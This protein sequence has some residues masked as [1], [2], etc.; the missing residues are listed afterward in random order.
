MKIMKRQL[1]L[2][3]I[4]LTMALGMTGCKGNN[5]GSKSKSSGALPKISVSSE[6][7]VTEIEIDQ[8]LQLAVK[9]EAGEAVTGVTWTSSVPTVASV[10]DAG[11][12][13][14]LGSGET[15]ITAK[16]DG[17]KAGNIV[18]KVRRPAPLATLHFE[19]AEH[20]SAD[21]WWSSSSYGSE[22]GP[23]A[24]PIYDK[25]SASDGT[26]VGYFGEGDKE[27][28]K[29]T[30]NAAIKAEFCVTMGYSS[31][32]DDLSTVESI[33]LNDKDVTLTD[34]KYE[35]EG[36]SYTFH[37]VS[38]GNLDIINGENTLE[39]SFKAAA[40]YID[41]L[42][43]YSKQTATI[44][45]KAAPAKQEITVSNAAEDFNIE[46]TDTV[47][48]NTNTTGA[49]FTSSSDSIATVTNTGLVTGVAKGTANITI[50]K[51]GMY[52]ARVTITVTE[53]PIA[54]EIKVEVETGTSPEDVVTFRRA[55]SGDTITDAFPQNAVLT[56]K[57][58]SDK[59]G[60]YK[61]SMNARG[62]SSSSDISIAE[63]FEITFN[64]TKL[65]LAGNVKGRTLALY[66][67][68]DVTLKAEENT[69]TVKALTESV[70]ALDYFK[71]VPN[72]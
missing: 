30:S 17:F 42:V 6:G 11:L 26:C 52:S 50:K 62:S 63:S 21:G 49:T 23:G 16:K 54:G 48:I 67:L 12:V 60:S 65:T 10:S 35:S 47:Q 4:A 66:E 31:S 45:L 19:D 44:Q 68:G 14:A 64:G 9:N 55:S 5:N 51:D 27:T 69:I 46:T 56:I 20:Y 22:R 8:T 53:K 59:A 43:L 7:N 25:E 61:L 13:T 70:P 34:V 36:S 40:P 72:A 33:K 29:F 39:I 2:P 57:F 38:I 3:V 24:K 28:L 41:D 1:F 18:I 58:N 37:E 32:V 71:L 15:T